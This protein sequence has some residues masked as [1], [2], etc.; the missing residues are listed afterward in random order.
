MPVGLHSPFT[1]LKSLMTGSVVISQRRRGVKGWMTFPSPSTISWIMV[2]CIRRPSL[3]I[4]AADM[5]T[6]SGVASTYPCPTAGKISIARGPV[7]TLVNPFPGRVGDKARQFTRQFDTA[8][9]VIAQ[10]LGIL[11]EADNAQTLVNFTGI[12]A[13]NFIKAYITGT[14]NALQERNFAESAR[15]TVE[16][17]G[18]VIIILDA[19]GIGGR[20]CSSANQ[21]SREH[22]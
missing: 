13:A 9:L 5:S 18:P 16:S 4:V 14:R 21:S 3:A 11:L 8:R 17:V 20:K 19:A 22:Q 6:C 7:L 15:L 10:G 12:T 2:G 1:Q